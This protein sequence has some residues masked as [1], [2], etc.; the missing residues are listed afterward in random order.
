[1]RSILQLSRQ[2]LSD[3]ISQT[4]TRM[5]VQPAI[6]EKDVWVCTVLDRL[7]T[8]DAFRE[9]LVF[10][11][12]TSLS[13]AFGIIERFSE[14]VDLIMDWR[15]I[16]Y[17]ETDT[18]PWDPERSKTQQAKLATRINADCLH[19]LQTHLAPWLRMELADVTANDVEIVVTEEQGVEVNYPSLFG[20]VNYVPS[21]VLLEIGPLAAWI[22]SV[23]TTLSP[24]VSTE[25][26][27]VVGT[28]EVPARVTS[29]ERTFWEKATILHQQA[30]NSTAAPIRY[31]RHYYDLVMLARSGVADRAIADIELLRQVV[32]F[33]QR[34]YPSA[35]ARYELATPGTFR[36]LPD[37]EKLNELQR[38]YRNMRV[39]FFRD[40]PVWDAIVKELS[41]LESAINGGVGAGFYVT[42]HH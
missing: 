11:G 35:R 16:G 28:V 32:E 24:Y 2:D 6:V 12:G 4:A 21:R 40:P 7:F 25:F 23:W 34:F 17:G 15:L 9:R 10:K 3:L 19:Y 14:D 26:P 27:N 37:E 41:A 13:K 39:M 29:A 33:K 36:L 1:M 30:S 5:K 31:A 8:S 18:D 22:P 38:D 42:A 20:I